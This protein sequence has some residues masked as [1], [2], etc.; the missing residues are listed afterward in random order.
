MGLI[1][2]RKEFT[3]RRVFAS[4]WLTIGGPERENLPFPA[5]TTPKVVV[6]ELDRHATWILVVSS[7]ATA[8]TSTSEPVCLLCGLVACD[9][10]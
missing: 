1:C 8:A 2:G 6:S 4:T 7:F 10:T 9:V 3:F 5:A